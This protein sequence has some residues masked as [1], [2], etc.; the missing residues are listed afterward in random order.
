[1]DNGHGVLIKTWSKTKKKKNASKIIFVPQKTDVGRLNF[2]HANVRRRVSSVCSGETQFIF[3]FFFTHEKSLQR[4]CVHKLHFYGLWRSA[5]YRV[6]T[7]IAI[8]SLFCYQQKAK[9]KTQKSEHTSRT[10]CCCDYTILVFCE[11]RNDAKSFLN[12][13]GTVRSVFRKTRPWTPPTRC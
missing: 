6:I 2:V 1:M 11:R 8:F 4:R 10:C 5:P 13:N 7:M 12:S 9:S 3:L